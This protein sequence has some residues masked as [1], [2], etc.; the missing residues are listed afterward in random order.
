MSRW[1]VEVNSI[2]PLQLS[3]DLKYSKINTLN[4]DQSPHKSSSNQRESGGSTNLLHRSSSF[5]PSPSILASPPLTDS[6]TMSPPSDLFPEP[7]FAF[8]LVASTLSSF[9]SSSSTTATPTVP[10]SGG[11]IRR[12]FVGTTSSS[13]PASTTTDSG[14]SNQFGFAASG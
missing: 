8:P 3:D 4:W 1:S 11:N 9:V 7:Q 14:S 2:P 5:I 10:T 13:S 12:Q 6:F